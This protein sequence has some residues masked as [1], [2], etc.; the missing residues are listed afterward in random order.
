MADSAA[1]TGLGRVVPKDGGD[2]SAAF[3]RYLNRPG[4]RLLSTRILVVEHDSFNMK[5]LRELLEVLGHAV[6]EGHGGEDAVE[7]ARRHRPDLIFLAVGDRDHR[8]IDTRQRLK[9]EAAL[10][11]VPVIALT[12]GVLKRG[13]DD[14]Q[15]AGFDDHLAKPISLVTF[16]A[17]LENALAGQPRD[18][19]AGRVSKGASRASSPTT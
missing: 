16:L 19:V 18:G 12:N 11:T 10:S 17:I 9:T 3:E 7:L 4:W 6:I 8:A 2:L 1:R 15:Q 13:A 14:L 5:L